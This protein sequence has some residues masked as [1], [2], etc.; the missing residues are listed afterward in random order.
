MSYYY[1]SQYCEIYYEEI[2]KS[3]TPDPIVEFRVTVVSDERGKY[4]HFVN[5]SNVTTHLGIILAPQ[6][7]WMGL[8]KVV[9]REIDEPIDPDELPKS[10]PVYKKLNFAERYAVF[11]RGRREP[12]KHLRRTHPDYWVRPLDEWLPE[13]ER[14][15]TGRTGVTPFGDY[16]Y[17]EATIKELEEVAIKQRRVRTR[18]ENT[19]ARL[20]PA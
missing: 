20:I 14:G 15:T 3:K 13:A 12:S 6:T 16:E 2:P 17:D 18:F 1:R 7:F 11:F 8:T 10:V 19:T 9:N 5:L 4:P